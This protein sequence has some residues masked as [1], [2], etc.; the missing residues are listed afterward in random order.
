MTHKSFT[1]ITIGS[2]K[3]LMCNNDYFDIEEIIACLKNN[4]PHFFRKSIVSQR[5]DLSLELAA[6]CPENFKGKALENVK[7]N[8]W[9]VWPILAFELRSDGAQVL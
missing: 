6:E 9:Q 5:E 1:F 4:F 8:D 2:D 3:M 7:A